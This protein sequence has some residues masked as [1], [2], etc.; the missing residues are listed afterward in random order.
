MS[1]RELWLV[2][3]AVAMA[4]ALGAVFLLAGGRE[5]NDPRTTARVDRVDTSQV[6]ITPE[7][8]HYADFIG[9]YGAASRDLARL[10]PGMCISAIIP[11]RS[12]APRADALLSEVRILSRPCEP[13]VSKD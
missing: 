3:G 10:K 4:V 2:G 11:N 1:K 7:S 6:C 13:R 9:C 5:S 12:Y 8:A